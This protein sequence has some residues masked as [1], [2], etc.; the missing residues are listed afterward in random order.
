MAS[1][2]DAR[3]IMELVEKLKQEILEEIIKTVQNDDLLHQTHV[4]VEYPIHGDDHDTYKV[5]ANKRVVSEIIEYFKA[6]GFKVVNRESY[7]T[8]LLTVTW[9]GCYDWKSSEI[10]LE[11]IDENG[12]VCTPEYKALLQTSPKTAPVAVDTGKPSEAIESRLQCG[13]DQK[14]DQKKVD[15]K[16]EISLTV[17]AAATAHKISIHQKRKVNRIV[18]NELANLADVVAKQIGRE[19]DLM[20][21]NVVLELEVPHLATDVSRLTINTFLRGL[22]EMGY[23][24]TIISAPSSTSPDLPTKCKIDFP[25]A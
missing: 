1:R 11:D 14:V 19:A 2:A 4:S 20:K 22:K 25:T 21:R 24:V 10:I 6:Y 8:G 17:L 23:Q 15:Q 13:A 3:Y 18:K 5:A 9:P 7:S 12:R 16:D